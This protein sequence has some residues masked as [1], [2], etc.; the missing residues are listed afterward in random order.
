MTEHNTNTTPV[1]GV[2]EEYKNAI[3][4]VVDDAMR[5]DALGAKFCVVLNEH[6]PTDEAIKQIISN[7][8]ESDLNVKGSL[9]KTIAE[10]DGKRKAR[11]ID[12]GIV[13]VGTA[14][15]TLFVGWV[16]TQLPK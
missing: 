7:A 10:M 12:R 2:D 14:V 11:W 9:E 6:K 1:V 5:T 13:A 16:S 15:F 4:P 8:I 3:Q